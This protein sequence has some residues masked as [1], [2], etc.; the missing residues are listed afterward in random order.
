MKNIKNIAIATMAATL[1]FSC[2]TEE[3][4][5]EKR[6]QDNTI[7]ISYSSGDA[8]FSNYISLGNSLTA[9]LM[10]AA[11]YTEGQ[12]S[13]FPNIIG[14]Q[15]IKAGFSSEF[16]QPD[17]NAVNGYNISLNSDP[18]TATFGKFILDTSIPGPVPTTPG[19]VITAFG[20]DKTSLNNFGVPGARTADL[21]TPAL[22]ANG[23]Y[24][25]FA[26]VPGQSTVLG[27][28]LATDPTFFTLWIGNND[29]LNYAS[30]GGVGDAPLAF[31]SQ[32][33]FTADY[34][35][36]IGQLAGKGAKGVVI[37]I[38][39]V[40][41][42]PYFRAVPYNPV[43]LDEA[44][45]GQLNAG[46]AEYNGGLQLAKMGGFIDE[47]EAE[48]RTITFAAGQNAFV[49]VDEDLTDLSAL[50]LPNYRQTEPT[51]LVPLPTST[52]LQS[53]IGTQQPAGDQYVLTLEEQ[54]A[55]ITA[56]AT[57]NGVIQGIAASVDGV[58]MFDIQPLFADLAGLT[59]EL[60]A[61]LALSTEA[62][63]ASDGVQG[64]SYESVTI[65]PDFSP[66][67]LFSTDGIHPNPRGHAILANYLIDFINE[68][69]DSNIPKVN[70]TTYRTV[71]FQ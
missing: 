10:D 27:D 2:D 35:S 36:I 1:I 7:E 15:L 54:T 6:I 19:D 3:D 60:A 17:I 59:P 34:S 33:Q 11:L 57:Y 43:P 20:G 50:G 55:I 45:A 61:Q 28:A 9:G 12:N 47:A 64:I 46:Y 14:N 32:S 52:A 71:L 21:L 23:F 22:A 29:V 51:D 68:K 26:T 24:A 16:N 38:P 40:L 31:Y 18:Q 8:D 62:Q 65:A 25:R 67:G 4:L 48:R 69:H 39:P 70:S 30:S 58:D 49:M 13:S 44:T 56:R 53:G 41:L 63:A 66:S 5:I 42:I 37:N